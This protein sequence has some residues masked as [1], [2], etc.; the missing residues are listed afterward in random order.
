MSTVIKHGEAGPR[1]HRP[2]LTAVP[3]AARR[4]A[5]NHRPGVRAA[6][7]QTLTCRRPARRTSRPALQKRC[8]GR[9]QS[10]PDGFWAGAVCSRQRRFANEQKCYAKRL[11]D[12]AGPRETPRVSRARARPPVSAGSGWREPPPVLRPLSSPLSR[13]TSQTVSTF[14]LHVAQSIPF[15]IP[16]IISTVHFTYML[17]NAIVI[18]QSTFEVL[19]FRYSFV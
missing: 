17:F 14:L 19:F 12:M 6:D 3:V 10:G 1:P 4:G 15:H 8:R 13:N 5:P 16:S 7:G 11:P 2:R 9:S 18:F